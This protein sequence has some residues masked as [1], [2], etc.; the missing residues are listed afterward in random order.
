EITAEALEA[1]EVELADEAVLVT[2]GH[3]TF[4]VELQAYSRHR[5]P[6]T[7][8]LAIVGA[9]LDRLQSPARSAALNA[10]GV[11]LWEKGAPSDIS[12]IAGGGWESRAVCDFTCSAISVAV[13]PVATIETVAATFT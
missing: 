8:A 1:G 12:G 11:G 6:P 4:V 13:E 10:W 3:V 9:A 5:E 2:E 7:G